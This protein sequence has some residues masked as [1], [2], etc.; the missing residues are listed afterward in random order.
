MTH[1]WNNL[2]QEI[3]LISTRYARSEIYSIR[4]PKYTVSEG[5]NIQYPRAEI[6]SIR[7]P[8]YTVSEGR[9]I[10]Y[11]RAEI[12][13]IRGPK[14]TVS[15]GI[16]RPVTSVSALPWFIGYTYYW[17]L[18]FLNNIIKW[19]TNKYQTV[20]TIPRSNVIIIKTKKNLEIPKW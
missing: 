15:E 7:G 5:R 6:Y 11:P 14:Y 19:K 4:G 13:S 1:F 12:Y 2:H 10:Q 9:N 17:N 16:L 3:C 8:K 18:Q 20:G